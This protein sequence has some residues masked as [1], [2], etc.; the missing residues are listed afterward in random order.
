MSSQVSLKKLYEVV[1]KELSAEKSNLEGQLLTIVD[2]A[3]SD[4]KQR[5]AVKSLVRQAMWQGLGSPLFYI[6]GQYAEKNGEE[7]YKEYAKRKEPQDINF[8]PEN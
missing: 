4:P 5:E 1:E 3:F 6:F 2:S 8:F 7:F